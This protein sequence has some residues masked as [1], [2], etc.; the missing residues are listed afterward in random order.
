MT[1]KSIRRPSRKLDSLKIKSL[2]ENQTKKIKG[3][4]NGPQWLRK[5]SL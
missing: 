2:K 4:P 3:G 1:G 5:T